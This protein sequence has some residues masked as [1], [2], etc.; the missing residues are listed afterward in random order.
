MLIARYLIA[1][2]FFDS[3]LSTRV[4]KPIVFAIDRSILRFRFVWAYLVT[5]SSIGTVGLLAGNLQDRLGRMAGIPAGGN[6]NGEVR[7]KR[8]M[9]YSM[10]N[11][12]IHIFLLNFGSINFALLYFIE[13]FIVLLCFIIHFSYR[14]PRWY[15][16]LPPSQ[17][18]TCMSSCMVRSGE[19]REVEKN[20]CVCCRKEE[21]KDLD[22]DMQEEVLAFWVGWQIRFISLWLRSARTRR[23]DPT[24]GEVDCWVGLLGTW[25]NIPKIRNWW[26]NE[27]QR[28]QRLKIEKFKVWTR[29]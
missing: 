14:Y 5:G 19:K 6:G 3:V 4:R 25:H 20:P 16:E 24:L 12:R 7:R 15:R 13:L 29:N 27:S 26:Q 1:L 8:G 17:P 11:V 2:W 23:S 21:M 10:G 22:P 28:C 9:T 18:N